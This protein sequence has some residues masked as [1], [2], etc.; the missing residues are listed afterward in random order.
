MRESDKTRDYISEKIPVAYFFFNRPDK[1]ELSIEPIRDYAPARLF[2]V[3]DGPRPSKPGEEIVV[4]DTRIL[5]ESKIDWPCEV[6]KIYAPYNLG[7]RERFFS[8]LDLIFK[9][10]KTLAVVEDDCLVS[11]EF[12]GFARHVLGKFAN[13]PK[14][15]IVSASNF[16]EWPAGSSTYAFSLQPS[17]W[18]WAANSGLWHEFRNSE[19]KESWT[20]TEM[21]AVLDTCCTKSQRKTWRKSMLQAKNLNTWDISFAVFLRMNRYL[22]ATPSV[23]LS[24]NI[25]F[26]AGAVHTKFEYPEMSVE[27]GS[28]PKSHNDPKYFSPD[29]R[30][31]S[32]FE[33][34]LFRRRVKFITEHPIEFVLRILRFVSLIVRE[35]R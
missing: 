7:L 12:F 6:T 13:E 5:V 1:T 18:G 28:L 27:I 8:A 32:A 15:G 9:L 21:R 11:K 22:N 24:K 23:N 34:G 4:S 2:L 14:L 20:N 29:C 30:I 16:G 10:E 33:K 31:D 19:Q 35:K 17:I 3:S 26:G 25:G